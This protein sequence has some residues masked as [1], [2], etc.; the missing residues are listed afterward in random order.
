MVTV[1]LISAVLLLPMT[2]ADARVFSA[3]V[4]KKDLLPLDMDQVKK[5]VANDD[6]GKKTKALWEAYKIAAQQHGLQYLLGERTE[7]LLR[8]FSSKPLAQ[9]EEMGDE[10]IIRAF[11]KKVSMRQ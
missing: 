6:R 10:I 11:R 3:W 5:A 9:D 7:A 1:D 4:A 8:E 2:L